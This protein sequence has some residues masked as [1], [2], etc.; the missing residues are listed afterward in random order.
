MPLFYHL[1]YLLATY[2]KWSKKNRLL[3]RGRL[4]FTWPHSLRTNYFF[5]LGKYKGACCSCA[6]TVASSLSANHCKKASS[7]AS[8][9]LAAQARCNKSGRRLAVSHNDCCR[10]HNA[11]A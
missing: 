11:M 3:I 2:E 7:A 4:T 1:Y 6:R 5:F 8:K 10:R 9:L